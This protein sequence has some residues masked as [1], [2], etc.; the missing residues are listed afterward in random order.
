MEEESFERAS[1]DLEI[2]QAAYPEELTAHNDTPTFFPLKFTLNLTEHAFVTMEL[3][4]GYPTSSGVQISSYRSR[5]DEKSRMEVTVSAIRRASLECQEEEMEGGITCCSTALESWNDY[6]EGKEPEPESEKIEAMPKV[7]TNYEWISGEPLVDKK[8][9]FQA[10]LCRLNS[11]QQV[12]EA[13]HQ[14]ITG[15]SKIRRASHNM[16]RFRSRLKKVLLFLSSHF[17][18]VLWNSTL[19]VSRKRCLTGGF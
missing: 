7:D 18:V 14:L 12:H 6:D 13:L 2:I 8:S 16:V 15:S 9:T 11:E 19:G 1:A 17:F 10:H 5:P 3:Q 4:E